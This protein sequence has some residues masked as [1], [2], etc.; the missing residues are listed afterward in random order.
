MGMTFEFLSQYLEKTRSSSKENNLN[1]IKSISSLFVQGAPLRPELAQ[2]CH[3]ASTY[4]RYT[5]ARKHTW[6][7]NR[8]SSNI[9]AVDLIAIGF[10]LKIDSPQF[11]KTLTEEDL[12]NLA[13]GAYFVSLDL[14]NKKRNLF[15]ALA[16]IKTSE[17]YHYLFDP[18]FATLFTSDDDLF[19]TCKILL[20][21]YEDEFQSINSIFIRT[22]Y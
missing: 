3:N 20:D 7:T 12:A 18:N 8:T 9:E 19:K 2:I 16:L 22:C 1:I 4:H 6:Y 17:E 5:E 21:Q 10:N 13:I 11:C 15:H 14:S